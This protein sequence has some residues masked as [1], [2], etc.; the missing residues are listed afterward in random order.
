M[1]LPNK[2]LTQASQVTTFNYMDAVVGR[3]SLVLYASLADNNGTTGYILNG[4]A[5]DSDPTSK[6]YVLNAAVTKEA[7]YNFDSII[8]K[9]ITLEGQ[10]IFAFTHMADNVGGGVPQ[11]YLIIKV[12]HWDGTTETDIGSVQSSL[13]TNGAG[14]QT[15]AREVV[16]ADITKTKFKQGEYLRVTVEAWGDGIGSQYTV[17]YDT[18]NTIAPGGYSG[19]FQAT[20]PVLS[21]IT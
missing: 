8:T 6:T 17:Y 2:Y 19:V 15:F 11:G 10:A 5:T 21:T 12:R 4:V 18:L 7:D 1:A 13:V 14:G 9:P 3:A 16:T 20:L